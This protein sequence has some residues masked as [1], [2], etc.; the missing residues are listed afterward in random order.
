MAEM[1]HQSP[2]DSMF[3]VGMKA[4]APPQQD[5]TSIPDNDEF[6][7]S[8]YL[9][10]AIE[11]GQYVAM[12]MTSMVSFSSTTSTVSSDD[13]NAGVSAEGRTPR[14]EILKLALQP[15]GESTSSSF[16]FHSSSS[17]P[18]PNALVQPTVPSN[19]GMSPMQVWA[20]LVVVWEGD[21]WILVKIPILLCLVFIFCYLYYNRRTRQQQNQ[22]KDPQMAL[23]YSPQRNSPPRRHDLTTLDHRSSRRLSSPDRLSRVNPS[24]ASARSM[25]GG[26]SSR[27][28]PPRSR[29]STFDFF[30]MNDGIGEEH[31]MSRSNSLCRLGRGGNGT[32]G[33]AV[34]GAGPRRKRTG[35]MDLLLQG[36]GVVTGGVGGNYKNNIKRK[37]SFDESN[38]SN[39]MH[40]FDSGGGDEDGMLYDEFGP[41]T[42]SIQLVCH[43]PGCSTISY[44]TWTPPTTVS[45]KRSRKDGGGMAP[46]LPTSKNHGRL[47]AS[48]I[49]LKL[50][51]TVI[52]DIHKS[53][54]SF[55]VPNPTTASSSSSSSCVTSKKFDFTLPVP[56]FSTHV[57]PP[58]LGG[59][60]NVYVLGSPKDEWME[61]TFDSAQQAAQ[62]QLDLI[63]YQVLGKTLR[64]MYQVLSLV[65]QGSEAHDGQEFVLHDDQQIHDNKSKEGDTVSQ[66]ENNTDA[67]RTAS[68]AKTDKPTFVNAGVAWDDALRALS[69]IPSVRIALERLWLHHRNHGFP[70]TASTAGTGG[71]TTA[72]TASGAAGKKGRGSK[73]KT[74]KNQAAGGTASSTTLETSAA[75]PSLDIHQAS[76]TEE[77][78]NKRLLLGPVDFFRLF[79]PT[80]PETAIPVIDESNKDRM[81]QL[82]RWRKRVARA[83]VLV[84]S[85]VISHKV[86]NEGWSLPLPVSFPMPANL[87]PF[88]K[89]LAYDDNEDNNRR[90]FTARNEYYEATVSR[91]VLCHVRPDD[92]FFQD[93]MN[94]NSSIDTQW[95]FPYIWGGSQ[96]FSQRHLVLSP[97]QAYSLVAAHTFQLPNPESE[98][99][100]SH[101]LQASNDPVAVI[102]SLFD[103]ISKHP[104][105]DFLISAFYPQA[106]NI[107]V[108]ACYVRSLPKGIDPAFDTVVRFVMK[109]ERQLFFRFKAFLLLQASTFPSVG[110]HLSCYAYDYAPCHLSQICLW[111]VPS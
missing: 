87:Q 102:P 65:H 91:D 34:G 88:R 85:Y 17:L 11:L 69:S 26:S 58:A 86:V 104:E 71:A 96:I 46:P 23:S 90:D 80:L 62:F 73:S 6:A 20:P 111:F 103:L 93:D 8:P 76:L 83:A 55:V 15:H 75:S 107:A 56:K 41:I 98:D 108:V 13:D 38:H 109:S 97:C 68:A 100:H 81:E 29:S 18:I 74:N 54:L 49:I 99:Y 92:Y 43:G 1:D 24:M 95:N 78:V 27:N 5:G 40:R 3:D 106:R 51:R 57:V 66:K 2:P 32:G 53:S 79:V 67:D 77:Y 39:R 60:L 105:V 33:A 21:T 36:L 42:F 10:S 72:T 7:A 61:Y 110:I 9:Q 25:I 48:D 31:T 16:E 14:Q 82:L 19:N 30:G 28:L 50:R 59:V 45:R 47:L 101:P 70:A 37:L 35:S 12:S 44:S 89:R 84:R 22:P 63:A 94:S 4:S 52:L 64:N